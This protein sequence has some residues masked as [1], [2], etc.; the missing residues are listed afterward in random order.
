MC[1]Q[2]VVN[3]AAGAEHGGGGEGEGWEGKSP[4]S[5]G[6]YC[7]GEEGGVGACGCEVVGVQASGE[8]EKGTP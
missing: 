3:C 7:V 2:T 4:V 6:V 8:E 5:E 1:V